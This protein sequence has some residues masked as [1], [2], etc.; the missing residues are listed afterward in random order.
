[1]KTFEKNLIKETVFFCTAV[2]VLTLG[3]FGIVKF[4]ALL[5]RAVKGQL[6]VDGLGSLLM[7]KMITYLDI[8]FTPVL[9]IA[10][11]LVLF[12]W[13][14][15]NEITIY[16]TAGIGPARYMS[17]ASHI[18]IAAATIVVVL[19]CI[20]SPFAERKFEQELDRYQVKTASAPFVPGTFLSVGAK[21]SV[22]FLSLDDDLE[23]QG[24]MRLFY[25]KVRPNHQE[26]I[27]AQDGGYEFDIKQAFGLIEISNGNRIK[28][29]SDSETYET[30]FFDSY[31]EWIPVETFE[32]STLDPQV[33]SLLSLIRS[34][35]WLDHAELHWRLSKVVTIA[36]VVMLGF[37]I[38]T[39]KLSSRVGWHLLNAI[40]IYFVYSSLLGFLSDYIR[41]HHTALVLWAPHLAMILLIAWIY[42]R[43]HITTFLRVR[44]LASARSK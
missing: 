7:Y 31:E 40:A 19:S 37:V 30:A 24:V 4:L 15:D 5:R 6:P 42:M 25:L 14:R 43:H 8:V 32:T 11:L 27:V 21:P 9:F 35:D 2:M 16:A 33:K 17:V 41:Q 13:H 18:A 1:M 23:M 10:I 34:N 22:V 26:I 44:L 39:L 3:I 20:V 12:R 38:G 28:L 36:V 29:S